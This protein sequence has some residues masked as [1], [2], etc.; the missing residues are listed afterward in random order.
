MPGEIRSSSEG[1]AAWLAWSG[2]TWGL[3]VLGWSLSR[4]MYIYILY[5]C[6]CIY[7]YIDIST[8]QISIHRLIIFTCW[9]ALY[10]AIRL[11][12]VIFS[13]LKSGHCKAS[14]ASKHGVEW[15]MHATSNCCCGSFQ[16][17]SPPNCFKMSQNIFAY[18]HQCQHQVVSVPYFPTEFSSPSSQTCDLV[19]RFDI[20]QLHLPLG[21]DRVDHGL[22]SKPPSQIKKVIIGSLTVSH[23]DLFQSPDRICSWHL[24]HLD[25]IWETYGNV[26]PHVTTRYT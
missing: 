18:T 2:N 25:R 5:N 20:L 11:F 22:D 23:L 6:I 21:D 8:M 13:K 14:V 9:C 15:F 7:I 1:M 17:K 12:K 24:C 4:P 16:K 10:I 3:A 19:W 26:W